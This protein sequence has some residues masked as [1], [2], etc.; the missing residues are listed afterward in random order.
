VLYHFIVTLHR[1]MIYFRISHIRK[2]DWLGSS[3]SS[4]VEATGS[5]P[6]HNVDHQHYKPQVVGS[7]PQ[8]GV[9]SKSD[10]QARF[11]LTL[12]AIGCW[13]SQTRGA[14]ESRQDDRHRLNLIDD[15]RLDLAPRALPHM[16]THMIGTVYCPP[17]TVSGATVSDAATTSHS[18]SPRAVIVSSLYTASFSTALTNCELPASQP[19][20]IETPV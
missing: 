18:P 15:I 16:I 9:R 17:A 6:N 8:D 13:A 12:I 2:T 1:N 20:R 19:R 4:R 7:D 14:D 11:G 3:K 10:L 5:N